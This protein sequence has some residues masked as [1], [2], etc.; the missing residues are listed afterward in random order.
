MGKHLIGWGETLD[1]G[2]APGALVMSWRG[3]EGGIAAARMG[4]EAIMTP[5]SHCYFDYRNSDEP[6]EPGNLGRITLKTVYGYDPTPSDL[7]ASAKSK[8]LGVQANIWTERMPTWRLV[9][10]MILPR[11]CA[12]AEVAWSPLEVKDWT[13]FQ[14]RLEGH[15]K[16]LKEMDYTYRHPL[17]EK[18]GFPL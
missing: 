9:E 14:A 13:S 17:R 12:L 2:L 10:Y 6:E 4:H 3:T 7:D 16:F 1:G 11:L 18:M 15:M 5:P 8:I